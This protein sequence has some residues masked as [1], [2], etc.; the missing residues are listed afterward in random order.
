MNINDIRYLGHII[1]IHYYISHTTGMNQLKTK[2]VCYDAR[3]HERKKKSVTRYAST[4]R[5]TSEGLTLL[6]GRRYRIL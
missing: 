6:S 3:S 4:Q 2:E 1:D 5:S